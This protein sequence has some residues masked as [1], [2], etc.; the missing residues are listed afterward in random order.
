MTAAHEISTVD[1]CT[2]AS[3]FDLKLH[4]HK[5]EGAQHGPRLGIMAVEHGDEILPI[6]VIRQV[7]DKID[8]SKLKGSVW[9][10]PVSNPHAFETLTR[11]NPIDML[12][13]V[14]WYPGNAGGW[15]S[16]KIANKIVQEFWSRCD[17]MI[18]FH[19]GGAVPTVEYQYL[20]PKYHDYCRAFGMRVVR[21]V[22][23]MGRP[24]PGGT[25]TRPDIP[26]VTIELGGGH[27][28][29]DRFLPQGIRG[30]FNIMK[31]LGMIEG[32]L[33]L[34]KEQ[35][36]FEEVSYT[37]PSHGGLLYPNTFVKDLGTIVP[38]D[39]LFGTVVSPYSFKELER[40]VTP[41]R[42]NVIILVRNSITKV[43]PGDFAYMSGNMETAHWIQND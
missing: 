41:F 29:E 33:E 30:C 8:P 35:L 40:I 36:I 10:L 23:M 18:N 26:S 31:H 38:K 42:D 11:N 21:S 5:V 7:L 28:A 17:Y 37:R 39:Y 34:P 22:E 15:L 2:M 25:G 43:H 4:I 9:A 1:V 19:S 16:E 24:Q 13:M 14:R 3:G 12:D 6:E 27:M 20:R 32:K